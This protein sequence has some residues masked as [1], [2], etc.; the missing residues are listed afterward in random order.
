MYEH[1]GCQAGR[2]D[3]IRIQSNSLRKIINT[4]AQQI[5]KMKKLHVLQTLC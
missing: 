1:R 4:F 5:K 3:R 2:N